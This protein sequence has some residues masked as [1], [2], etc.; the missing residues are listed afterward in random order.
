MREAC[1]LVRELH[2]RGVGVQSLP[3][4]VSIDASAGDDRPTLTLGLLGLVSSWRSPT[5]TSASR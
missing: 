4:A 3:D 1:G 5:P 2:Q